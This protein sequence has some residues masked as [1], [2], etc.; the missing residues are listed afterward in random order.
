M[1]RF[2]E[3]GLVALAAIMTGMGSDGAYG[4]TEMRDAGARTLALDEAT[5]VV[6]GML[7]EAIKLDAVD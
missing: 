5:C 7:K 3:R 2:F 1:L 4:L 6:F